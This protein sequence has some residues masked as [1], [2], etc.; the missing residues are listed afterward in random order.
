MASLFEIAG[1]T[2]VGFSTVDAKN[3]GVINIIN[4]LNST[5]KSR[6][7]TSIDEQVRLHSD[8]S[9]II[10]DGEAIKNPDFCAMG[11]VWDA[12]AHH[13]EKI[14]DAMAII[15]LVNKLVDKVFTS[16]VDGLIYV[17]LVDPVHSRI[18]EQVALSD[19][20][21][22]FIRLIQNLLAMNTM[23]DGIVLIDDFD[24]GVNQDHF[25]PLWVYLIKVAM[26]NNNQVFVVVH[27][28]ICIENYARTISVME[29]FNTL[30]I[31]T[32]HKALKESQGLSATFDRDKLIQW[33]TQGSN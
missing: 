14:T 18:R 2:K 27:N 32:S 6:L 3:L 9:S 5:G 10:I 17:E 19:M 29:S 15:K 1:D 25:L 20:G 33:F 7:L 11:D 31:V 16:D 21:T 26:Q 8:I 13:D 23:Q 12:L 22:T 30:L 4:G 28:H 24:M